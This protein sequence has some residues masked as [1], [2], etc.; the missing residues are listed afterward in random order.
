MLDRGCDGFIQ[1]PYDLTELAVK[2]RQ[3]LNAAMTSQ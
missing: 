3:I 2:I 1:K